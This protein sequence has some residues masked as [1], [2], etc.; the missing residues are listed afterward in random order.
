VKKAVAERLQAELMAV[1]EA[2][3]AKEGAQYEFSPQVTLLL[4]FDPFIQA[5]YSSDPVSQYFG[6]N[7]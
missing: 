4:R 6:K 1:Y 7:D 3:A 5:I 2:T